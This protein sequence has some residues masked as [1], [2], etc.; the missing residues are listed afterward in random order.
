MPPKRQ[1]PQEVTNLIANSSDL[2]NR[3]LSEKIWIETGYKIPSISIRNYRIAHNLESPKNK[4][5]ARSEPVQWTAE[6]EAFIR[7]CYMDKEIA[8][9]REHLDKYY[10]LECTLAQLR[11]K[12]KSMGLHGQTR[13]ANYS[14]KARVSDMKIDGETFGVACT[15]F[16]IIIDGRQLRFWTAT[17]TDPPYLTRISKNA[18]KAVQYLQ[19]DYR[20]YRDG[21]API[22]F[23]KIEEN[24]ETKPD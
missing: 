9:I 17:L 8:T 5:S 2:N 4:R 20:K 13:K 18:I 10:D 22:F 14:G 21:G 23:Q 6:S 11:G 15:E 16:E 12:M 7:E 24:L 1:L 3:E 19:D